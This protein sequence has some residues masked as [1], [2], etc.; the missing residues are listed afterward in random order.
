MR[1]LVFAYS[2][3]GVVGLESLIAGGHIV[4]GVVTHEDN[5][6]EFKWFRSVEELAKAHHIPVIKPAD[7]NAPEILAWA[8]ERRPD[9]VF[10]F[11]YRQMLKSPLLT[12]APLGA[13]NLHGSLLPKFRGRAPVNWAII[14]GAKETGVTL[15]EMVDKPDA[16][17][18]LGQRAVPIA[19]DDTAQDV[20]AK[21]VPEA[22]RLL[23]EVVPLIALG[24]APR[25]PQDGTQASYFGGRKPEDGR[26][27]W[28]W[29]ARKIH[30]MVRAL[31]RPY[32]GAYAWWEGQKLLIWKGLLAPG[33]PMGTAEPGTILKATEAGV[34]VA[35]GEGVFQIL[36]VGRENGPSV[37]AA[38]ILKQGSFFERSQT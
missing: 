35:T 6:W 14:E 12:V 3:I 17:A 7:P 30:N 19:D 22:R 31:A 5:P 1:C 34:F 26:L 15:H 37:N 25:R 2:E 29:P 20:F 8:K 11:Y 27:D 4:T 33:F 21:L 13:Y 16:G 10:S 18:I 36:D 23:D 38:T 32:P 28:S 24:K 9:V